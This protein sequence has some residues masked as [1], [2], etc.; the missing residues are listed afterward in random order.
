MTTA[1]PALTPVTVTLLGQVIVG[2]TDDPLKVTVATVL[3]ES[4]LCVVQVT[5]VLPIGKTEPD[6]GLQTTLPPQSPASVGD[7]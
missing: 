3:Q 4:P 5:V 2:A 6:G 1:V 7:P